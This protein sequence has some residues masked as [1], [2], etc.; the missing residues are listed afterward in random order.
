MRRGGARGRVFLIIPRYAYSIYVHIK[1]TKDKNRFAT[2]DPI[3]A[4]STQNVE[5][6]QGKEGD[7]GARINQS[8]FLMSFAC[9]KYLSVDELKT[10]E[11]GRELIGDPYLLKHT[12]IR[13]TGVGVGAR[14]FRLKR[15]CVGKHIS[16]RRRRRRSRPRGNV[17]VERRSSIKHFIHSSHFF[18]VPT[19]NVLVERR[20][21]IK[22]I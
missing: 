21:F 4:F 1:I 11:K 18:C 20:S 15:S 12:R 3:L 7:S 17:L 14:E 2:P 9:L 13:R 8:V 5:A 10:G 19:P 22:H 6:L 16:L